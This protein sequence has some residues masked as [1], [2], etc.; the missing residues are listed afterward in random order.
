ML[1][2]KHYLQLLTPQWAEIINCLA[3]EQPLP[4]KY[5]DHALLASN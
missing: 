1:Y 2:V 4:E 5:K 3:K